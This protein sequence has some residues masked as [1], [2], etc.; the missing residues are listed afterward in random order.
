[1]ASIRRWWQLLGGRAYPKA[2]RLLI[3]ADAGGS[4]GSRLRAWKVHLKSCQISCNCR[5][6]CVTTRPARVSGT[7]LSIGWFSF[8]SMHWKGRPL[9]SY[10][11]VV[12]LIGST[13]TRRGLKVKAVRDTRQY[14][15]GQKVADRE[16]QAAPVD[17][18]HVSW[19][20]ELHVEATPGTMKTPV[21]ASQYYKY[22]LLPIPKRVQESHGEYCTR[23]SGQAHS[24][25]LPG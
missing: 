22:Y 24:P 9:V 1:M 11:A 17:L 25:A 19:R 7:R 3:C 16:L 2:Q 15:T 8:V 12:N 21:R 20:L 10:E 4:N 23:R 13:T 5:S 18:S 14:P 6:R